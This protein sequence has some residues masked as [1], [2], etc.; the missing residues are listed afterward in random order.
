MLRTA[1]LHQTRLAE[2][3][4]CIVSPRMNEI[5]AGYVLI[6]KPG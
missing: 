6:F 2:M 1:G 5:I 4:L 3:R